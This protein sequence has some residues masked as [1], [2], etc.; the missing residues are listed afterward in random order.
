MYIDIFMYTLQYIST[1]VKNNCVLFN[2][3]PYI[4]VYILTFFV[5]KKIQL[6]V[7]FRGLNFL[8]ITIF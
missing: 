4:T 8:K 5:S 2:L 7:S 3:I 1:Y 6:T